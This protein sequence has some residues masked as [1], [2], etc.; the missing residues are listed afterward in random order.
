M[1]LSQKATIQ[2]AVDL[3]HFFPKRAIFGEIFRFRLI[4]LMLPL[5]LEQPLLFP[6]TSNPFTHRFL[7]YWNILKS[8][9]KMWNPRYSLAPTNESIFLGNRWQKRDQVSMKPDGGSPLYRVSTQAKTGLL[10][11]GQE[12]SEKLESARM[13]IVYR[14]NVYCIASAMYCI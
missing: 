6:E 2:I 11:T 4:N 5:C 7:F 14:A 3:R 12:A 9:Q 8:G 10:Y 13:Y 1:E